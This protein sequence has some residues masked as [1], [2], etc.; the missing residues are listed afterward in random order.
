MC[1]INSNIRNIAA[2]MLLLTAIASCKKSFLEIKPKG[3]VI[4]TKTTDYDLLF[5]NLDLINISSD[6]QHILGD[7]V[8][9]KDPA[10]TGASFRDKQ[11]FKWDFNIYT[12]EEDAKET[13]SAVKG[14]Y[15]YNKIIEE[16]MAST[17]GSELTKTSLQ[18]EA[19]A[20]RAWCNL[21]L[22]NFY[23][24][25]YNAATAATDPGFPLITK[26]D[27]NGSDY[28][29]AS[30][31]QVYDL[32]VSDLTTA[33][34]G[35]I[36]TGV[37]HRVRMSK[38]AARGLLAKVYIFMGKYAEALPL[39]NEAI[40]NLAQSTV[41]TGF[42]NFNTSFPGFPTTVNDIENVY[43][44]NMS[45]V[46]LNGTQSMVWLTPEAAALYGPTD[47]RLSKWY[48]NTTTFPNGLKLVRRGATTTSAWGVRVP[49]LYLFRAEVKARA[50]DLTGAVSDLE[51]L[52]QNRMPA[53][54]AK[55][56]AAAQT[57][58]MALLT[59]IMEERIR[60][61]A[62]QGFRWYDMR[63]LSADPLFPTI[64]YQHRVYDV[65]GVVKETFTL[66]KVDQ[67]VFSMPPKIVGENPNINN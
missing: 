40:S 22:I 6:G 47:V 7:E 58:K 41:T 44:K 25:P 39:L 36:N 18:A 27:V 10:Y 52:R 9:T 5:N 42:Y 60:E 45:N 61:F 30:V 26:A 21:L 33:I 67:F 64:N 62:V 23:G 53:A 8:A 16:V 34:P 48:A 4:A 31:Q 51:F 35:L 56:P 17:E 12:P 32:I 37:P 38:A 14:L 13:L 54:D 50:E 15:M 29:R 2:G 57:S 20:G 43:A 49:E 11:L 24:K 3:I 28:R 65:N 63:R 19:Y 59:F 1:R 55:V 46:Y 66:N